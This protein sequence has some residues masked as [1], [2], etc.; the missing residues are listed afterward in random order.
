MRAD[1]CAM[2]L[3]HFFPTLRYGR[4]VHKGRPL[5]ACP[6][7]GTGLCLGVSHFPVVKAAACA[8]FYGPGLGLQ[9]GLC[10]PYGLWLWVATR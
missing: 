2:Q 5:H 9:T 8:Y 6:E 10:M 3:G 1:M 7:G 4:V